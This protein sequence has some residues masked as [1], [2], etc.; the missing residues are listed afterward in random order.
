MS[1]TT[2]LSLMARGA[3][4]YR[5]YPDRRWVPEMRPL[6]AA[7][8]LLATCLTGCARQEIDASGPR[9]KSI[10]VRAGLL[11][12]VWTPPPYHHR[13]DGHWPTWW[14]VYDRLLDN[15]VLH[16][17][18]YPN[19]ATHWESTG[20]KLV[21]T[22]HLRRDVRWHD[23]KP[24]TAHDVEA[25][26]LFIMDGYLMSPGHHVQFDQLVGLADYRARRAGRIE[27]LQVLDDHTIRFELERPA[28][29]F[30]WNIGIISILPKHQLDIVGESRK[31]EGHRIWRDPGAIGTGP[32]KLVET[33]P[34][35]YVRLEAYRDYHRG[36]PKIDEVIIHDK[37]AALAAINH[38]LDLGFPPAP[39]AASE[40]DALP[41]MEVIALRS[42]ANAAI[43]MNVT[44][45]ELQDVRVRRALFHAIDRETISQSIYGAYGGA[46]VPVTVMPTVAWRHQDLPRMEYDPEKAVALLKEAG[47]NPSRPLTIVMRDIDM[48]GI[49]LDLATIAQDYWKRVGVEVKVEAVEAAILSERM[50]R[51]EFD[52]Y[53]G[54]WTGVLPLSMVNFRSDGHYKTAYGYLN[55]EVDDLAARVDTTSN[56]EELRELYLKMQEL[57]WD[58]V[59]YFPLLHP[60]VLVAKSKRLQMGPMADT[61]GY[62]TAIWWHEWDVVEEN[63]ARPSTEELSA[64]DGG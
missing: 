25:T 7:G 64:A 33:Q 21:H 34:F 8:L 43:S 28:P 11:N 38:Q 13:N 23:G 31:V 22:F 63:A 49:R 53:V 32:F 57:V 4:E 46:E 48:A 39:S 27:G 58:D 16:Q 45:P 59:V 47:W 62:P 18:K 19:L 54:G 37:D 6:I 35:Q 2:K 36:A 51:G 60:V 50:L 24:F 14:F 17:P 20:D 26:F 42:N 15:D 52:F 10:Q 44:L 29:F 1:C 41:H 3:H 40:I 30:L 55:P 9:K 61:I 12:E 5:E 56:L